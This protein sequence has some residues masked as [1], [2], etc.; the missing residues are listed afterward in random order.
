ML[1]LFL[2]LPIPFP[3]A[4]RSSLPAGEGYLRA[5][6]F[7]HRQQPDVPC[8]LHVPL[9]AQVILARKVCLL[10]TVLVHS[11]GRTSLEDAHPLPVSRSCVRRSRSCLS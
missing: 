2:S 5:P 3:T 7:I 1:C 11:V 6:S 9:A 4:Q 10:E 8:C